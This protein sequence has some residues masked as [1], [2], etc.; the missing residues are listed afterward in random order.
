MSGHTYYDPY[1]V[2]I[3]TD[4]YPTLRRLR[5]EAPLYYNA[6]HDFYPVSRF[7]DVERGLLDREMERRVLRAP[8]GQLA[9]RSHP[10][11]PGHGLGDRSGRGGDPEGATSEAEQ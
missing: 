1:D 4:P 6:R 7:E 8:G 10:G 9:A 2:E 11:D 3:Y 5:E